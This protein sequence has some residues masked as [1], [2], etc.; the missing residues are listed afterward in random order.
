MNQKFDI[1]LFDKDDTEGFSCYAKAVFKLDWDAVCQFSDK[2]QVI[3]SV[4]KFSDR[5][6]GLD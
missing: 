4:D 2:T 5:I 6:D 1:I 3:F